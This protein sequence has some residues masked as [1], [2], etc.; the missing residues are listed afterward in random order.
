MAAVTAATM[1]SLL[2]GVTPAASAGTPAVV[3]SQTVATRS[4][5]EVHT[6]TATVT[7]ADGQPA[8]D[9]TPVNFTISG[10]AK[11]ITVGSPLVGLGLYTG[12]AGGWALHADGKVDGFAATNPVT[13]PAPVASPAVDLVAT[14]TGGGYWVTTADGHVLTAGDAMSYGDLGSV[15]LSRPIVGMSPTASGHGYYLVSGDGGIF[16]FGDAV[17]RGSMGGVSLAAPI[18]GIA[19]TPTGNG[20]WLFGSNGAVYSF[21]DA[22]TYGDLHSLSLNRPIVDL[23]PT[24]DAKGYWMVAD[25]GGI[26]AFG[27]AQFYGSLGGTALNGPVSRILRTTGGHG[28]LMATRDGG[29][30]SFGDGPALTNLG[31]Y[32]V[33]TVG[34]QATLRFS[35]DTTGD[36]TVG[37]S[38]GGSPATATATPV[39][40]HWAS[41]P[42]AWINL[43]GDTGNT[44]LTSQTASVTATVKDADGYPIDD[45][46]PVLFTV[47]GTGGE[48]PG[49]ATV[50]TSR[51]KAQFTFRSSATGRSYIVA[52]TGG[53]EAA[54]HVDWRNP[55]P[56]LRIVLGATPTTVVAGGEV[57]FTATVSSSGSVAAT[58]ARLTVPLPAGSSVGRVDPGD[59]SC[60]TDGGSLLCDTG[61]LANPGSSTLHFQLTM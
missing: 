24:D 51:G 38:I 15:A 26:F 29:V 10:P 56:D 50:P 37:A 9:G 22:A 32:T 28:Y 54:A 48:D 46:T 36:S 40:V 33:R 6:V 13:P 43:T 47:S 20:Y 25:D 60:D 49:S 44:L 1:A 35:S 34:G 45:G 2:V 52:T 3:L 31:G 4:P 5:G 41:G 18:I 7:G 57:A 11:A 21:G 12:G 27:D 39:T 8:A 19:P 59:W 23:A 42:P 16:C 30:W 58:G 61:P 17:F 53:Q 14:P 55:S